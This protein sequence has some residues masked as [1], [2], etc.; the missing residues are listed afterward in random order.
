[1][2]DPAASQAPTPTRDESGNLLSGRVEI[3][4]GARVEGSELHDVTVRRGA[5]VLGCSLRGDRSVHSGEVVVGRDSRLFACEIQTRES[6]LGKKF[7]FGPFE[8]GAHPSRIGDRVRLSHSL[9]V[10]SS[11]GDGSRGSHASIRCSSIGPDNDLRSFSNLILSSTGT[12]CNLGSEISKTVLGDGFV[13]EH[14]SS[15]LSLVAPNH[16]PVLTSEGQP[17]E[18]RLP[19]V[20]NIGAGT[21]FANY[22]GEPLPASRVEESPG[23]KKGTALVF[24]AFTCINTRVVNG[25]GQAGPGQSVSE[26]YPR[27]DL[28]TLGFGS[29]VENKVTGRVPAFSYGGGSQSSGPSGHRIG[30]VLDRKPGIV[31]TLIRKMRK[32]APPGSPN[33]QELIEGTIRLE[34][35][36]LRTEEA[37]GRTNYDPSQ[38]RAGLDLLQN[39]LDGRW[40]VDGNGDWLH[41]WRADEDGAWKVAPSEPS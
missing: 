8:S 1:M 37:S 6:S 35:E 34:I 11:I 7:S 31:L 38:I 27:N 3:E 39:N 18:L 21:V 14:S 12:G 20:T 13:S 36:I 9:V 24:S 40:A 19:N 28:T 10:N 15:Y 30:W 17:Q 4:E 29:F 23:S 41:R 33:A 25:Y 16:F 22:G 26:L 2:K 5:Q 32:A